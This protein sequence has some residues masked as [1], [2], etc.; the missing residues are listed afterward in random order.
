MTNLKSFINR[1]AVLA[2]F[3]LAFALSWGGVFAAVGPGGFPAIPD[4]VDT[5]TPFVYLAMLAGPSL[6]GI[7]LTA[8][9]SGRAGLRELLS[10]LLRW[11]VGARWYA[12]ALLFTPLLALATLLVL[13]PTSPVFTPGIFTSDAKASVLLLG[14][15][16]GLLVGVCEELGWTG[17]AVPR[18]R[19]RY[20]VLTTGLIVGLLWG[21]WHFVLAFWASGTASGAISLSHFLPWVLYNLG[22]LPAYRVLMVWLYDRTGSLLVVTLMHASLT[23]GLALTMMPLEIS[24]VSNLVWYLVLTVALWVLV[25]AVGVAKGEQLARQPLRSGRGS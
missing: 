14:V 10:R 19:L 5:Q 3:G 22:V 1:H 2:Y 17:F 18:L 24:G 11:R 13:L 16:M 9:V 20:G 23:G 7:L 21:A 8:L 12:V 6:A 15:V 25:A 4:Q